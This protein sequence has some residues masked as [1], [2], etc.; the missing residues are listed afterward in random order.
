MSITPDELQRRLAE[1]L[2]RFEQ[3]AN[4]LDATYVRRDVFES[5]KELIKARDETRQTSES[6]L[7]RRI[8]DLEDDRTAKNRLIW[9][10]L[11]SGISGIIVA[12]VVA[13]L[14]H[15]GSAPK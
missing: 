12:I 3:L 5:Y 9:G 4:R 8:K 6:S 15:G 2:E 13:V 1:V 7:E 11:I 10:A 14:L